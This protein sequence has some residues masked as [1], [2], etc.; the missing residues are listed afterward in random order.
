MRGAA[1]ALLV[2]L[3]VLA[4]AGTASALSCS[5][6]PASKQLTVDM[7]AASYQHVTLYRVGDTVWWDEFTTWSHAP[8]PADVNTIDRIAVLGGAES[9]TLEL[10][11]SGGPFAPGA[12]PEAAGLS[13]IEI[14]AE[15]GGTPDDRVLVQG[16][17]GNDTLTVGA[18]GLSLDD[19]GD[20]DV[21]GSSL[22]ANV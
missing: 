18:D 15:L 12:T 2:G 7:T 17:A 1:F 20:R 5:Y 3:G 8:C 6:D 19:D 9:D 16:S 14:T 4:Q 13:E 22:A 21:T 10:D 11:L